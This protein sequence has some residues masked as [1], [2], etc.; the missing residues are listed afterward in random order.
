VPY[1]I[2]DKYRNQVIQYENSK[3]FLEVFTLDSETKIGY[4][5]IKNI[6]P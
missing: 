4:N 5:K 1:Y 2:L 3:N 6:V